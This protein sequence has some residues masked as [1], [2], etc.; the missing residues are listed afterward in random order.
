MSTLYSILDRGFECYS[1]FFEHTAVCL[2]QE[3]LAVGITTDGPRSRVLVLCIYDCPS[4]EVF[5]LVVSP[6]EMI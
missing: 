1:E 2:L 3:V 6:V 4:S 5:A